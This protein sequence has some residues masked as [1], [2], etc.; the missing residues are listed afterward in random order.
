MLLSRLSKMIN[1][2]YIYRTISRERNYHDRPRS[3]LY[4]EAKLQTLCHRPNTYGADCK[5]GSHNVRLI[6]G[7]LNKYTCT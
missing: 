3:L 5:C 6:A 7:H 4:T 2:M 1:I